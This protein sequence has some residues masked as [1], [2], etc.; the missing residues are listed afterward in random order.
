MVGERSIN[1]IEHEL[2]ERAS[3]EVARLA[4]NC[5]RSSW[6]N[7]TGELEKP[8]NG[9][10]EPWAKYFDGRVPLPYECSRN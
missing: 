1:P 2:K 7:E 3:I 5:R 4:F 10:P 6:T 8:T 9:K